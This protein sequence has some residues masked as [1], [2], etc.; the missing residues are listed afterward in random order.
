M[1]NFIDT[2]RGWNGPSLAHGRVSISVSSFTSPRPGAVWV[3]FKIGR[4]RWPGSISSAS[5]F[6]TV[7]RRVCRNAPQPSRPGTACSLRAAPGQTRKYLRYCG[8]QSGAKRTQARFLFC[9]LNMDSRSSRSLAAWLHGS[10][11]GDA[12][13]PSSAT[14]A[15]LSCGQLVPAQQERPLEVNSWH[16]K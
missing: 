10:M 9:P 6:V 2:D 1:S 16:L 8:S 12:A 5:I 14:A 7:P 4:D 3:N 15:R 11:A 13:W